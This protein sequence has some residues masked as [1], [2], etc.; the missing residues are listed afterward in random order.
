MHTFDMEMKKRYNGKVYRLALSSGCSCPNRA[1]KSGGCIFCSEGG[2]GEFASSAALPI[3]EQLEHA[4]KRVALKLS[5][6]FA[7]YCAYFQSFTN[8]FAPAATLAPLFYEAISG[9]DILMLSIA[10]RPDCLGDDILDMLAGLASRKPLMVELG[11]QTSRD[12]TARLIN[13]G[14]PTSVYDEAVKNLHSI[15]AEVVT[16]M[17]IGLPD[18]TADD[19]LHTACHIAETGSDGIK[20]QMLQVLRGT[21]LEKY[22]TGELSWEHTIPEYTLESYTALLERMLYVLPPEMVIHRITGDP[23]RSLLVSP[24]WTADKKH[25]L[26]YIRSVIAQK[27]GA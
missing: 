11:L 16:H 27:S 20:I 22:F 23:P 26:N 8:T 1:G 9:D 17:I 5:K 21:M 25:V 14:Y 6:S 3:S 24:Q 19:A 10:T 7:G 2:S 18:E 4:K 12:D 15:G 13:R